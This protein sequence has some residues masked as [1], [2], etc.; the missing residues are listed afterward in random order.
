MTETVS[1]GELRTRALRGTLVSL[2]GQ[3]LTQ[4][5]RF[6]SNI[7]LTRFLPESA[8]GVGA[9]IFAVTTGLFLISDVGIGTSVVRSAREDKAFLDTAWTLSVVRGVG[10]AI[11]AALLGVPA[12]WLYGEP[13]LAWLLPLCSIM[14][15]VLASESTGFYVAQRRLLLG[16]IMALEIVAQIVALAVSIPVAI[17]T[18]HVIALVLAAVVSAVVKFV[19]SFMMIPSIKPWFAWDRRAVTEIFSFGQWIFVSTLCSFIA[20]RWD[21][22]SLGRLEGFALLG[23]YGIATQITSVPNQ[24]AAQ[25]TNAVLTPVLSAAFRDGGAALGDAVDSARRAYVPA[26]MLLFLGAATTAPAFF[27]WVYPAAFREAGLMAQVL[28]LTIWL[29]FLQEASSRVLV[30]TGDG[31][32]LAAA[33]AL[34]VA[35]TIASTI[36]GFQVAGFWGFVVGNSVGAFVGVIAVGVRVRRRGAP[37]VLGHDVAATVIFLLLLIA[38]GGVPLWLAPHVG[39]E[40]HWL[41]LGACALVCGP[42]A[43][44]TRQR[45]KRAR[46]D[47]GP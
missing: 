35:V 29:S 33:N 28:M 44:L 30:A 17:A 25:V 41:T 27:V 42:L 20:M 9:I 37:Q 4:A 3:L 47:R 12:A 22:F 21:V 8:F 1:D 23:V 11:I 32:G 16:R 6:A 10:L 26:A 40:S 19:G 34:R 18:G 38:A 13:Q 5:L 36:V 15:L 2:G 7:V 31:P 39:V 14:V 24:M 46:A 43:L 45:V